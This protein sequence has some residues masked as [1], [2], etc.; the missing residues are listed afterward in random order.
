[1][2]ESK[3]KDTLKK[4]F[5]L[6]KGVENNLFNFYDDASGKLWEL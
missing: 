3:I 4:S 2:V 1:M 5:S 6:N